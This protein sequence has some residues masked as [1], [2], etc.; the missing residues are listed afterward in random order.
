MRATRYPFRRTQQLHVRAF[1]TTE[2][3]AAKDNND[4]GGTK[5]KQS[6][7]THEIEP[8]EW[9]YEYTDPLS[10]PKYRSRAKVLSRHDYARQNGV[11]FEDQYA[12]F[13][14]AMI[15]LS[16]LD[17]KT[18]KR[19]YENYLS[20]M[21]SAEEKFG[22]T[23]HEYV[24]RLLAQKFHITPF[25]A[26]AI[27]QLQH[28]EEQ[29]KLKYPDIDI[30]NDAETMDLYMKNTIQEAYKSTGEVPPESFVEPLPD[31]GMESHKVMAVDDLLD[32]DRLTIAANTRDQETARMMINDHLYIEDIDDAERDIPMCKDATNLIK[33]KEKLKKDVPPPLASPAVE[34]NRPP[35]WQFVAQVIDTRKLNP[36]SNRK[37]AKDGRRLWGKGHRNGFQQNWAENTLIEEGGSLRPAN[38]A[39]V[40]NMSWKPVRHIQ[41]FTYKGVKQAWL[42]RK[43]GNKAAWGK[44]PVRENPDAEEGE[45]EV[46]VE[47]VSEEEL[48]GMN[49]EDLDLVDA[50]DGDIDSDSALNSFD[51]HS[52]SS[53]E[54]DNQ[55]EEGDKNKKD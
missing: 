4:G 42:Q 37:K 55:D 17:S 22:K 24:C 33:M 10:R 47:V 6:F 43:K 7:V 13:E 45:R 5:H 46:E 35:R 36:K 49:L 32:V 44:A 31:D 29:F 52:F 38:L 53:E 28:S 40:R 1:S 18:Q 27:I 19:I 26:A 23:S 34:T 12:T 51:N 50:S 54:E 30:G 21:V 25:R 39:E 9:D 11:T 41:E 15:T 20:W 16:W 3:P 14:D 48:A 8:Q 2:A